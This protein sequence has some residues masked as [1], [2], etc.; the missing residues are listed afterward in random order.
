M[1]TGIS[2]QYNFNPD[3]TSPVGSSTSAVARD[4]ALDVRGDLARVLSRL[5]I[6]ERDLSRARNH[7]KQL[8]TRCGLLE[9][10]INSRLG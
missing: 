8:E 10:R 2:N 6:L 5:E 1:D 4:R 9:Q 3:S 7:I